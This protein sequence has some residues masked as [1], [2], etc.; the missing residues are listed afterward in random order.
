VSERKP[1]TLIDRIFLFGLR[2]L[3]IIVLILAAGVYFTVEGALRGII[4]DMAGG[5]FLIVLGAVLGLL[6]RATTIHRISKKYYSTDVLIGKSAVAKSNFGRG[7]KGVVLLENEYW[8][9]VSDAE[10]NEGDEVIVR[11]V[12]PDKVTLKVEKR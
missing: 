11:A 6:L 2:Q 8:S 3:I 9:A 1:E 7:S 4:T 12:E 5:I 10:I